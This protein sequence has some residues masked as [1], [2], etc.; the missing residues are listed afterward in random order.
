MKALEVVLDRRDCVEE[1]D[2]RVMM[3][4]AWCW[5]AWWA[6]GMGAAATFGQHFPE[7]AVA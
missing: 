7:Y 4:V 2:R 5:L 3:V 6:C 1:D